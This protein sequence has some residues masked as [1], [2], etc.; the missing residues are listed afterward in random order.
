[1]AVDLSQ[2]IV[3]PVVV[4]LTLYYDPFPN[5]FKFSCFQD[6][7]SLKVCTMLPDDFDAPTMTY[8]LDPRLIRSDNL[9]LLLMS[10]TNVL[11]GSL[12]S[13]IYVLLGGLITLLDF[14]NRVQP[15]LLILRTSNGHRRFKMLCLLSTVCAHRTIT[16]PPANSQALFAIDTLKNKQTTPALALAPEPVLSLVNTT[17]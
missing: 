3:V 2:N 9:M 12:E 15:A 11:I 6:M 16:A 10:Q 8:E 4:Y 14:Q 17:H 1:M 5:T 13:C 7:L